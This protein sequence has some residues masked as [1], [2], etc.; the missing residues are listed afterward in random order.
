MIFAYGWCIGGQLRNDSA[1]GRRKDSPCVLQPG[2]GEDAQY[3]LGRLFDREGLAVVIGLMRQVDEDPDAGGV[4][5]LDVGQVQ[6][7]PRG[8]TQCVLATVEQFVSA[9]QIDRSGKAEPNRTRGVRFAGD[10]Q[11]HSRDFS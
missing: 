2:Q 9:G 5:E 11:I 3:P 6:Q 4:H 8:V 10:R 1:F 7:Q